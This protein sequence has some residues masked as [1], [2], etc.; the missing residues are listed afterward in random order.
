MSR[1]DDTFYH[2]HGA[3]LE[4][5]ACSGSA[6]FVARHLSPARW[7]AA[8]HGPPLHCL[9]KCYA[10]PA[11][12]E[13]TCRPR[14]AVHAKRS[15]V[16][17]RI[18]AGGGGELDVY[19]RQGGYRALLRA[20]TQAPSAVIAEIER[21]QL[22]GRG[23]AGFPTGRKLRVVAEQAQPTKYV[24]VNADEGDPG[25]FSD[26]ILMEEDPHAVL[27]GAAIAA[28][29]VGATRGYIY[30]RREYPDAFATLTRALHEATEAGLM[31]PRARGLCL[32]LQIVQGNGSY[33]CGEETALLNSIERRRPFVRSRPPYPGQSGLFGMPTL[34]QNVETLVNL[35]FIVNHGAAAYA[36]LGVPGSRGTKLVSLNSL[37]HAPGLYEVE[38][39]M[40]L[41]SIV[42]Q[43]GQGM[44]S[45]DLKGVIVGGPL[46]AV[47]PPD[48][49]DVPFGFDELRALGASVGHG[50]V[51]AFDA[52]T[53]IPDLV[54]HVFRFGAFE[55]CGR[56]VPCRLGSAQIAH[57]L[58]VD[59]R[60][61]A[62]DSAR[63]E[64]LASVLRQT[65]LCGHGTGLGEFA[66]SI[67]RHY[68]QELLACASH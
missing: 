44:K 16:L 38:F 5:R 4:G 64:A 26:R 21:A 56:C 43:L 18:A 41:R 32:D 23:G 46:A 66:I 13:D 45:G 59:H 28:H 68:R 25:A 30:V 50:G 6:C 52:H 2:L 42:D 14:R 35:P 24:V 17:E 49:L 37:F 61:S 53:S 11:L 58:D 9:G 10:A 8:S 55:S 51:I 29:A 65:S 19:L 63:F 48:R 3:S 47:L 57:M 27:E 40:P 12:S 7:D 15:I 36:A 34:V 67:L 33:V 54:A 20:V 31:G 60:K 1:S 39:G 22:R 62:W